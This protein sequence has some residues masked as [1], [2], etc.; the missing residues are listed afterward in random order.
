M[1]AAASLV[2]LLFQAVLSPP[3]DLAC[4]QH[5]EGARFGLRREGVLGGGT[6]LPWRSQQL[7]GADTY[8][9]GPK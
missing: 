8:S 4:W 9:G 7:V 6:S 3:E 5:N 2:D 1:V